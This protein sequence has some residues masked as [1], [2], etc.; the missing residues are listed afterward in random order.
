M[1][2][3][4]SQASPGTW[5][6]L[7]LTQTT[8]FMLPQLIFTVQS[9]FPEKRTIG[10]SAGPSL[11]HTGHGTDSPFASGES[12]TPERKPL[13]EG[14]GSSNAK[15]VHIE[16]EPPGRAGAQRPG[17][18]ARLRG[19]RGHHLA[20]APQEAARRQGSQLQMQCDGSA[21]ATHPRSPGPGGHHAQ[22]L[23]SAKSRDHL[24][25]SP[26]KTASLCNRPRWLAPRLFEETSRMTTGH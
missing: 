6:H 21:P 11:I 8:I 26:L 19:A 17:L 18:P 25:A 16:A 2:D 15:A 9:E 10:P 23:G 7:I 5:A 3:S 20:S 12:L 1:R 14:T 22:G 4:R 24:R 13:T